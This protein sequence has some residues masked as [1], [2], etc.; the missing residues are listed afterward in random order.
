MALV[1]CGADPDLSH[2]LNTQPSSRVEEHLANSIP[3]SLLQPETTPHYPG[4]PYGTQIGAMQRENCALVLVV[5]CTPRRVG[6][7]TETVT[8]G[9]QGGWCQ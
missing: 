4:T 2:T 3:L 9:P 6:Q 1:K 7:L 8:E 5:H